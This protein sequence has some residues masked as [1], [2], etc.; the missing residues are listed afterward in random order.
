MLIGKIVNRIASKINPIG[1][2]YKESKSGVKVFKHVNMYG[3]EKL[4][5]FYPDGTPFKTIKRTL[6]NDT[7]FVNSKEATTKIGHSTIVDNHK[8]GV[9]TAIKQLEIK[10]FRPS[11]SYFDDRIPVKMKK[12]DVIH[13]YSY[14]SN[15]G[16]KHV[17]KLV[18]VEEFPH[19]GMKINAEY[20][21]F[22]NQLS[23]NLNKYNILW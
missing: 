23:Y 11:M 21:N 5:S 7:F 20:D 15:R 17:G 3:Q 14:C 19:A 1:E 12:G 8:T 9:H 4:S 10:Y 22:G 2:L 18:Y 13:R 6:I 16:G